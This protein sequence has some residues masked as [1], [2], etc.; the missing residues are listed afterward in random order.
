MKNGLQNA[1]ELWVA[2]WLEHQGYGDVRRLRC[3]PPDFVVGDHYAVEVTRLSQRITV[4]DDEDTKGE[5][6]AR[7][8]LRD[9]IE[10]VL[11]KLGSPGN[12]GRSWVIDCEYDFT[13]PLPTSKKVGAQ[14]SEALKPILKPYDNSVISSMHSRHLDC[15]KHAGEISHLGF[16]HLCLECGICLELGEFCYHPEGFFLQNVSDGEGIG[17]AVELARGIRNR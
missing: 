7:I 8:P 3:D 4:G 13:K 1:D 14:I 5:E 9:C 10:T 2:K 11:G 17:V 12:E 16:P 15:D 6:Q